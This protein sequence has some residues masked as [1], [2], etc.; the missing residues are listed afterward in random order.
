MKARNANQSVEFVDY[1]R[2]P[3]LAEL[4][5]R[6]GQHFEGRGYSRKGDT[7]MAC[8]VCLGLLA[9]ALT[10]AGL[11]IATTPEIFAIIY[12]V[13]G[14]THAFIAVN[15]G[16]D[17]NH[18]AISERPWVNHLLAFSMDL[19]GINSAIWR[20]LHHHAHHYCINIEG[21]DEALDGRGMLRFSPVAPWRPW[22]RLQSFYALPAYALSSLDYVLTKQ[23]RTLLY[24]RYIATWQF[25]TTQ[26]LYL[27]ISKAVYFGYMIV[28]PVWLMGQP[29]WV[30]I[31]AFVAAHAA[32]GV[33]LVIVFETTHVVSG[34]AFP[35]RVDR[36]AGFENHIFATTQDVATG[37][38]LLSTTIGGLNH[39]VIHHLFPSLCH[40]H[41]SQLT[42]IVR[43]VAIRHGFAYRE[44][45]SFSGAVS[46]HFRHLSA[47]GAASR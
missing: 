11:F 12:V 9:W 29:L 4:A 44:A 8:K 45:P 19:C 7:T 30:V 23:V 43:E 17:A 15:I 39:H 14:L 25:G 22:H 40:T 32:I 20:R 37:S 3:F 27:L 24:R 26:W 28:I 10:Y 33:I 1:S 21:E 35:E 18:G 46:Q 31:A 2:T 41:C 34:N 16:H 6:I 47:L 5:V 13:H 36:V 38:I 42:P